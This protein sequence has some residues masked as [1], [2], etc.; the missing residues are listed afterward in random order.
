MSQGSSS[1]TV[2][3]WDLPT[4]LFHWTLVIL[5]ILAPITNKIGG[6]AFYL[7]KINGYMILSLILY[8]ILWGFVGGTTAR[9][10]TFVRPI[11]A[12]GYFLD[13]IRNRSR[14]FLGHNPLGG[15]MVLALLAV[16]GAQA[17][18]GLMTL[19]DIPA[20][21]EGPFASKVAESTAEWVS[22]WH[23]RGFKVIIA[24]VVLHLA[25]N[26][27]Y[28]FIKKDNLIRP[29]VT[30]VKPTGAFEDVSENR[31]GSLRRAALCLALSMTLVFGS[32]WAFGSGAFI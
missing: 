2:Q 32:V 11:S 19:D 30:G 17:I 20:T 28:T 23:R 26:L 22:V 21:I 18:G 27:F 3:A 29:M 31:P 25:A 10:S 12:L 13:L 9:F 1:T 5:I 15:L 14:H 24:L 16:V 4:R 6:S 7:H 8:R